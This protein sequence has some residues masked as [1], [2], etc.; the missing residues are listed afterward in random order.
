MVTGADNNF[1]CLL[2]IIIPKN[3]VVIARIVGMMA[4]TVACNCV[5]VIMTLFP[6]AL[7]EMMDKIAATILLAF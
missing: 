7:A 3:I 2:F 6:V 4:E 5:G 1:T